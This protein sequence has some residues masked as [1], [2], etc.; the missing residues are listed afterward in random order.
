MFCLVLFSF[1]RHHHISPILY[2]YPS[3]TRKESATKTVRPF[4]MLLSTCTQ[5]HSR[6]DG[7][8]DERRTETETETETRTHTTREKNTQMERDGNAGM[9][10]IMVAFT[11][12]LPTVCCIVPSHRQ[13]QYATGICHS[14][15]FWLHL[16]EPRTAEPFVSWPGVAGSRGVFW[17]WHVLVLWRVGYS[18]LQSRL[19][20][21]RVGDN[22][23]AMK[24]SN[25][26]APAL[27]WNRDIVSALANSFVRLCSP[28]ISWQHFADAEGRW[29]P[30]SEQTF[31]VLCLTICKRSQ[32]CLK[33]LS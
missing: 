26:M 27:H 9:H 25:F 5:T 10:S 21:W 11:P 8:T 3:W 2:I 12:Y 18:M 33:C 20:Q 32:K 30:V 14:Q 1:Q 15:W 24:H 23:V 16:F 19:L 31:A 7:D 6:T 13:A 17:S 22:Y 28:S 4:E 29:E